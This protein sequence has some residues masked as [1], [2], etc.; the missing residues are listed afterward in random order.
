MINNLN[1]GKACIGQEVFDSEGNRG[2]II[3]F[4]VENKKKSKVTIQY[5]DGTSH[6]REKYSVQKGTF[7]KPY[8]DNIED[9]LSSGEWRYIPGFN[10]HYIISKTGVIKSAF[11]VNKGKILFPSIDSGGYLIIGL[12]VGDTRDTR[13]LCRIHRLMAETFIRHPENGE[14]VNHIDGNKQNNTIANL[15]II[16]REDNNKKYIDLQQLGLTKKE[17]EDI[18][19]YCVSNNITFKDYILQK[20]KG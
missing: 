9:D 10:N 20:L 15:E 7:R 2:I 3:D 8:L 13:K 5:D 19:K 4:F 18:E 16:S 17:V 12:Q 14:E 6:T 11:S 1:K